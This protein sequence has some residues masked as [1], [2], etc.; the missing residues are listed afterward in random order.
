MALRASVGPRW[1]QDGAMMV[2]DGAKMGQDGAKMVQDGAKIVQ[3]GAKMAQDGAQ[4][5]PEERR[6]QNKK[7]LYTPTPDHPAF[8]GS[9]FDLLYDI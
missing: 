2:Q 7:D 1:S 6:K 4:T 3:D 5:S 9:V 8:A